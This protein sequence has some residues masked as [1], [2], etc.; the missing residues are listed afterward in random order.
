MSPEQVRGHK[1]DGRSDLFS[2][3]CLFYEVLTR[4]RP[5]H[6]DDLMAIFYKITHESPDWARLP[7]EAQSLQPILDRALAKNLEDRYQTAHDFA[8]DLREYLGGH[9]SGAHALEALANLGPAPIAAPMPLTDAAGITARPGT[10]PTVQ[11]SGPPPV[12]QGRTHVTSSTVSRGPEDETVLEPRPVGRPGSAPPSTRPGTASGTRAGTAPG[13]T[14]LEPT[15]VLPSPRAQPV[16][17]A[18]PMLYVALGGLVVALGAAG[19]YIYVSQGGKPSVSPSTTVAQSGA[20][21]PSP[22]PS[23]AVAPSP[24]TTPSTGPSPPLAPPPT[25]GEARGKAAV[26]VRAAQ[27]AFRRGDYDQAIVRAQAALKE[28]PGNAEASRV[29]EN[30]LNGQRAEV[31]FRAADAAFRRNDH[32][33]ALTEAEAGRSVAPWDRRGPEQISRIQEAQ[34]QAQARTQQEAQQQKQQQQAAQ[35]AGLLSRAD[36]ALAGQKYDEAIA[37][38]DEVLRA[39]PQNPRAGQG[40]TGAVTA[41]ALSQAASSGGA[42]RPLSKTFAAGKTTAQ[43][44]ETTSGG[45]VPDGFED[46]SSTVKVNRG[47]QAGDLP[48]KI[49]FDVEPDVMKVGEPYKVRISLRN[50]GNAP[51]RI[52]DMI[53]TTRIN[54]RGASGPVSPLAREVAP[55]QGALLLTIP[56]FWKEDTTSW[57][58]EVVVRTDRGETYKNQVTWK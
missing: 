39:D 20:S 15:R 22:L 19:T 12:D 4:R 34:Q 3:G 58:M 47:T 28:D 56:D 18:N 14:R 11:I 40:K 43:S 45:T 44:T 25:F 24:L 42:A 50:E 6:A 41:R 16:S 53:V 37:L 54:G 33:Q 51:I 48:G 46:N 7:E 32:T 26:A 35:V 29:V 5:F 13:T 49:A 1:V 2:V 36:T 57:S 10:D 30:A 52:R 23:P 9:P 21:E 38:Y 17:A 27:E 31:H 55:R 8:N